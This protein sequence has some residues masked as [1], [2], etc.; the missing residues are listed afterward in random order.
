MI[1]LNAEPS[2]YSRAAFSKMCKLGTVIECECRSR[3]QLLEKL[4]DVEILIVRLAHKVDSVVMDGAP[5]LRVIVTATTGLNHIDMEAA[6]ERGITVLSLKGERAF[7]DTLTATAELTWTIL[8]AMVRH[9]P[10]AHQHVVNGGW[11]RDLFR[12]RQLQNKTLGIIGYGRLGSI[13]A[14][15]GRTF[16]MKV[17]AHDP[18]VS[19]VPAGIEKVGLER[20]LS[21]SD[22]ISLHVN[23]D[24]STTGMIDSELIQ[25]IKYGAVL[26][27]TSRGELVDENALLEALEVGRLSGVALDVL[28]GETSGDPNWLTKNKI[29]QYA[30]KHDNVILMPHVGGA[31]QESMEATEL[32]MVDKLISYLKT[33]KNIC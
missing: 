20:V 12:G 22:V 3:G 1:V 5:S 9:V 28:S 24:S 16:M 19:E 31:T 32:F 15:Y 21:Q 17:L 30:Q 8:L 14:A 13:V 23:L 2:G 26:V 18:F 6:A 10:T 27:N 33:T 11:N 4:R 25:Q 7:L 29:W